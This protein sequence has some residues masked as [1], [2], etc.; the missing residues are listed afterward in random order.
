MLNVVWYCYF[1]GREL[2]SSADQFAADRAQSCRGDLAEIFAATVDVVR[3]SYK[4]RFQVMTRLDELNSPAY[5]QSKQ[6]IIAHLQRLIP[7]N[8]LEQT[9]FAWLPL[10]P[11]YIGGVLGR[12]QNL[13]GH[14][15]KDMS[16]LTQLQPLQQRFDALQASELMDKQALHEVRFY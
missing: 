10:L 12:V 11:R 14:V 3:C 6:D 5:A 4:L 2:P 15:P 13:P 16:L 1:E 8:A 7:S 9:P